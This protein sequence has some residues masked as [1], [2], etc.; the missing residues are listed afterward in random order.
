MLQQMRKVLLV[1]PL[2]A[3]MAMAQSGD[4]K[5]Y[6]SVDA[7]G[8]IHYSDTQP[9]DLPAE[10]VKVQAPNTAP[11]VPVNTPRASD[12]AGH[13]DQPA[14]KFV[15]YTRFEMSSPEPDELLEYDVRSVQLAVWLV[16]GLQA[17]HTLQ[18]YL[19]GQPVGA[20]GLALSIAIGD[21]ERGTH[22]A[23]ARLYDERGRI[24]DT[25]PVVQF[26]IR[27]HR[28]TSSDYY[29]DYPYYAPG[30]GQPRGAG[31]PDGAGE[32]AGADSIEDADSLRG[33]RSPG[34]PVIRRRH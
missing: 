14:E 8:H 15:A 7:D 24:L 17:G 6:R 16:P 5:I 19:D 3:G 12:A 4:G 18:F 22:R 26:H 9:Q 13:D 28:D 29:G 33:A 32:P 34:Q 2:A 25:T 30:A 10:T 23:E 1:L 27:L 31:S 21:L 11:P 20:P